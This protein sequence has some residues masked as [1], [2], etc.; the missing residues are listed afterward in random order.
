MQSSHR[1]RLSAWICIWLADGNQ[2]RII[3]ITVMK[4]WVYKTITL[5]SQSI[6]NV[7]LTLTFI[8]AACHFFQ[9]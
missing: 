9:A 7:V 6:T 8:K 1:Q 3:L 5:Q 2:L 4:E